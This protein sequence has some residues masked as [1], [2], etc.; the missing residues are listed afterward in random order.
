VTSFSKKLVV[1]LY[2][3]ATIPAIAHASA[4]TD[5][6]AAGQALANGAQASTAAGVTNGSVANTVNS[7]N[8][9]YYQYSTNAPQTSLYQGGNGDTISAGAGKITACQT[10]AT[11]PDQF[12]QQNCNAI[13]FMAKN[14]STRPQFSIS[15]TDPNI[16]LSKAILANA[17]TLAANSLG[18]A[19]PAA[20]GTS[21][22]GCTNTT[23]TT[24]ATYQ[25]EVC[26]DF[27]SIASQTCTMGQTV[28]VNANTSYQ[29]NKT[30]NAYQVQ[31]CS[32]TLNAVVTQPQPLPA[33][34]NFNCPAGQT[35]SGT[36]CVQPVIAA[37]VNYSCSAGSTLNGSQC[38]PAPATAT[39]N[40]SCGAGQT[41]SGTSCVTPA[42][43]AT[44]T[45]TCPSGGSL[46][47][48]A[49]TPAPTAASVTYSCPVGQTLTGASCQA[50]AYQPAGIAATATS[51]PIPWT[52]GTC[53]SAGLALTGVTTGMLCSGGACTTG[54]WVFF[55]GWITITPKYST[56]YS[57]P[58]GYT[59]SGST[60]Y[61]PMVT[62]SPTTAT[63]NYSC[64]AGQILSGTSCQAPSYGATG[65]YSC[66]A[67]KT[68]SGTQCTTPAVSATV[69][70]SCPT[71]NTLTGTTCYPPPLGATVSY[72]CPAGNS[73]TGTNCQPPATVATITYT[74]AAGMTLSGTM[75][76]PSPVITT[77]VTDGCTTQEAAAL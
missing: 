74:C 20:V 29:C 71:G 49:C 39:A 32:R 59:L 43:N 60:C 50:P 18:Y 41:L 11:N 25:T 21:F 17:P 48:T 15:P 53:A 36:S 3:S 16:A 72:T 24:P 26:N 69:S 76:I 37:S 40:Y 30:A 27:N 54:C 66:S 28:V 22:S 13:N 1:I 31:T 38:Q 9:T 77:S 35:L 12:L 62:P 67:G 8:P 4:Q 63:A 6:F 68:L 23:V 61:P 47:G 57:C 44:L 56:T 70:Y 65:N 2:L 5:A 58:S 52:A 46:S 19:N 55:G 73:L 10:G 33:T 7:F 75:C 42:V 64:A 34:P 14:P 45:Y 51:A